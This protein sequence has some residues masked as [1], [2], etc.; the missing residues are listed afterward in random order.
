MNPRVI[1]VPATLD[2]VNRKKDR[3]V[4]FRF[5]SLFEVSNDD[6]ANMDT[7][8][9][10]AGHMLFRENAFADEDV[11]DEDVETDIGK[12]QSTQVRDALW[13]LFIAEG[14]NGADKEAWNQFYRKAMQ[15]F[16]GKILDKVHLIEEQ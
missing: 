16:K 9:Q 6:F 14:G 11:P 12:S 10:S 15:A 5:T 13:V 1:Q 8:H 4:S 2:S 3:S 7:F